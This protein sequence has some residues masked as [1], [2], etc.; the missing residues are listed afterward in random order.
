MLNVFFINVR[1]I[2]ISFQ[3]IDVNCGY[4]FTVFTVKTNKTSQIFGTGLN[5]DSQ[6]GSSNYY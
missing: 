5:T 2:T 1:G 4:G 6:I 3:V